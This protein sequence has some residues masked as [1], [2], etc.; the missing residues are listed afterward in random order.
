MNKLRLNASEREIIRPFLIDDALLENC[1]ILYSKKAGYDT[2]SS[3]LLDDVEVDTL[4]L[5]LDLP[6]DDICSFFSISPADLIV[7]IIIRDQAARTYKVLCEMALGTTLETE[8]LLG[9]LPSNLSTG[10]LS[11]SVVLTRKVDADDL[12]SFNKLAQKEF[13]FSSANQKIDFPRVWKTASELREAG[14]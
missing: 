13:K 9:E 12:S 11:I 1:A 10:K 3:I 14:L 6:V 5:K 8:E 7:S 2:S 4:K